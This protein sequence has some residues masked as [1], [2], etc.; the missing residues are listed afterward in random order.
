MKYLLA[1]AD[2]RVV[3]CRALSGSIYLAARAGAAA[4]P[5]VRPRLIRLGY[6]TKP[7]R[8]AMLGRPKLAMRRLAKRLVSSIQI[9]RATT[10]GW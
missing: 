5:R 8:Y 6:E 1:L 9:R 4:L 7:L 10:S 2:Y 3:T